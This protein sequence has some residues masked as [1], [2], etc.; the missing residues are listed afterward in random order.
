M[1][2]LAPICVPNPKVSVYSPSPYLYVPCGK[3]EACV[4]RKRSAWFARFKQEVRNSQSAYFITFTYSDEYV[5]G[6]YDFDGLK[7]DVCKEHIQK[8]HRR[9][10]KAIKK[11]NEVIKKR[12]GLTWKEFRDRYPELYRFRYYLT[13][14]YG[15]NGIPNRPHYHACYFDFP[16]DYIDLI[17]KE[18]FE[19][20]VKIS[21]VN[22]N[23][24][25]YLAG[26]EINKLFTPDGCERVFNLCSKGLG[27]SYITDAIVE[28]HQ[29]DP[30]NRRFVSIDGQRLT[31]SRY[32]VDK[33]FS[34]RDKFEYAN[35]H[36]EK[37]FQ[38]EQK[39][40]QKFGID[41]VERQN[42]EIRAGFVRRIRKTYKQHSKL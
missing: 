33:I 40:I 42:H 35:A 21:E 14:E 13:A 9:L 18:W 34:A 24:L 30:E 27:L 15:P 25:R 6:H 36:S 12:E 8:F 3:C 10:R 32:Y 1:E 17:Q 19:G 4:D 23:R 2:C 20:F 16:P 5:D 26:Y 28:Y 31:M 7:L 38:V 11:R 22:D 41:E 37:A 39:R 29:A